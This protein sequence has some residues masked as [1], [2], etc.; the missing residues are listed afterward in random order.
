MS[1]S[2]EQTQP[3]PVVKERKNGPIYPADY[4]VDTAEQVARPLAPV[5]RR[6][7]AG[8]ARRSPREETVILPVKR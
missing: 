1:E 7:A 4:R 2:K 5:P 8:S 3:A 6:R